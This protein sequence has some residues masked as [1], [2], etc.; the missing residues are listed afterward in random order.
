MSKP[1]QSVF[2]VWPMG[3][4][5]VISLLR[6]LSMGCIFGGQRVLRLTRIY[7]PKSWSIT[8]LF[9]DRILH[10]APHFTVLF[11][12]WKNHKSF[13]K[14]PSD[15][16][17]GSFAIL[18][19]CREKRSEIGCRKKMQGVGQL[20]LCLKDP[21]PTSPQEAY[22]PGEKVGLGTQTSTGSL[23]SSLPAHARTMR[24]HNPQTQG[25]C[26]RCVHR[27]A[28]FTEHLHAQWCAMGSISHHSTLL[29][30]LEDR[31]GLGRDSRSPWPP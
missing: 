2:W 9:D 15:L 29:E 14:T 16:P 18:T 10:C 12:W 17:H 5:F 7:D 6:V 23:P 20:P 8:V 4:Q 22:R 21:H 13:L 3:D 26:H 24:C 28:L 27:R 31:R 19:P 30:D 1:N 25:C 11:S